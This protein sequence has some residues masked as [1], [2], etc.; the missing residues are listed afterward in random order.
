[1]EK[2][3]MDS[4]KEP[5]KESFLKKLFN[6]KGSMTAIIVVAVVGIVSLM[7][8]GFNQISY[9]AEETQATG[10]PES[11]TAEQTQLIF[12]EK[13]A[14]DG[15]NV[16]FSLLLDNIG[17]VP[18]F[19]YERWKDYGVGE[20]YTTSDYIDDPGLV[21]LIQKLYPG[22]TGNDLA[23]RWIA[24]A[25]IWVYIYEK[26][27]DRI[28]SEKYVDY[29]DFV[30]K[31]QQVSKLYQYGA[32]E[33]TY[34]FENA[35][36][37]AL[38][39]V[40]GIRTL[41]NQAKNYSENYIIKSTLTSNKISITDGKE[42][43]QS[44]LITISGNYNSYSVAL[45]S[46]PNGTM[47]IDE[48]GAKISEEQFSVMNVNKFYVR[49]P[50]KSLTDENKNVELTVNGLFNTNVAKS[51]VSGDYQKVVILENG[52]K[53]NNTGLTIPFDYTPTVPNTAM[54]VAE[55]IYFI[56]LILLLSGV[57]IVYANAKPQ[58]SE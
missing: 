57:G 5:K 41:I 55:T 7:V 34:I 19:C 31:V 21:Y 45:K 15:N 9:A 43:Y 14:G 11:F 35:N 4:G 8:F 46:A 53:V 17:D 39:D 26:Y 27:P 6:D 23:D 30:T 33:G 58:T 10:M 13:L 50:V 36:G 29:T 20:Q 38:F 24:Q 25:A 32:E 3:Y 44:D 12:G 1:M 47:L 18:L 49:V 40:Y 16:G 2:I 42:Y 22:K 51:Y 54:G 48:N 56:G 52:N 37:S 28:P